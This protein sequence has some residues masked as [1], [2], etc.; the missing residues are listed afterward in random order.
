MNYEPL[1]CKA[2]QKAKWF[3]LNIEYKNDKIFKL[4]IPKYYF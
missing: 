4:I 1:K 3:N 2:N